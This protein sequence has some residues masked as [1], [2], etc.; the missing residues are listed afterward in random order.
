MK[1]LSGIQLPH[2][3]RT[4]EQPVRALPL[5]SIVR[6]PMLMHTGDPCQPAV[7]K[8]D[9]VLLGQLIGE[10]AAENAVPIHASVSGTVSAISQYRTAD[11]R[12]VPCVEI[13]PDGEQRIYDGCQPP[14]LE[15]KDDLIRAAKESGCVGLGGSGK[16]TFRKLL[17]VKKPQM[18][19]V[20]GAE[21]EPYL[22]S[23]SR[24]MTEHPEDVIEGTALIMRLMKIK[25]ARI[26]IQTDKPAAIRK[27]SELA[28][29]RKGI[30]V[31]PLPAVYPQ[32]AEK[33]VI[34]HTCGKVIPEDQTSA[35]LGI[36]TLNVSTV[37]FL[38]QY[39]QT[40]IPLTERVVTVDGDAVKKPFNLRVPIGTSAIRLLEYAGCDFD[41]LSELLSGGPMMGTALP[42]ADVPIL[43]PQNGLLACKASRR[44]KPTPCIRCGRCIRVCPLRLMPVQLDA[45]FGKQDIKMLTAYRVDLCMNCGCCSYV[46]PA[47]RPLAD[48][49]QQ[50]K[51]LLPKP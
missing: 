34:Y 50:A 49:I 13:T 40:G 37:A 1:R 5:P 22:T 12:E 26:G 10:A 21:C 30:T 15:S 43:K 8:G 39:A 28:A 25:E 47:H 33:V 3:K 19:V 11:G 27:L 36:L 16:P 6:L 20:N 14:K 24:M 44:P 42:S 18:L 32:G 7:Q 23:D 41:S 45:A 2:R 48:T 9:H 46:C 29:D 4:E 51:A 35:D 31:C 38:Q 17:A